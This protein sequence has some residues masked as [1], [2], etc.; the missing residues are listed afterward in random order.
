M[1][2]LQG[3]SAYL[4]KLDLDK[5]LILINHE[6]LVVSKKDFFKKMYE[7]IFGYRTKSL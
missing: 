2:N 6:G 4:Y 7:K 5:D 1:T 3:R